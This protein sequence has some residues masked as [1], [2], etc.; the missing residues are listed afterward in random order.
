M[1]KKFVDKARNLG[2]VLKGSIILSSGTVIGSAIGF[3]QTIL[4]SN[5]LSEEIF[6]TYRYII[7][8]IG[9]IGIFSLPGL[10]V[11]LY[12]MLVQNAQPNIKKLIIVRFLASIIGSAFVILFAYWQHAYNELTREL[13]VSYIW[14]AILFPVSEVFNI[15]ESFLLAKKNY[16]QLS[17]VGILQRLAVAIVSLSVVFIDQRILLLTLG[18]LISVIAVRSYAFFKNKVNFNEKSSQDTKT[19]LLYAVKLSAIGVINIV[20][21]Y[22]DKIFL[23]HGLGVTELAMYS[24]IIIFADQGK[25]IVKHIGT[26]ELKN[27]VSIRGTVA[28]NYIKNRTNT[29]IPMLVIFYAC[30]A[31]GLYVFF[32]IF[33]KYSTVLPLALLYG[34]VLLLSTKVYHRSYLEAHQQSRKLMIFNVSTSSIKILG[35]IILS[36]PLGLTGIVVALILSELLAWIMLEVIVLRFARQ[37]QQQI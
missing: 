33:P 13:F 8:F 12:Q 17:V 2:D 27:L 26:I 20:G 37:Q 35:I 6:G 32:K 28:I 9:T 10:S 18:Y 16:R 29:L 31:A 30:Y 4:L 23:F 5:Y 24:M 1:I 22:F 21:T 11:A 34:T 19:T 14:I 25:M 36:K 3:I 15:Y 7:S